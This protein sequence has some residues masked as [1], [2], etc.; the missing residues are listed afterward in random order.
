MIICRKNYMAI[1]VC[2]HDMIIIMLLQRTAR[3]NGQMNVV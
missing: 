1:Y 2:Y 3:D